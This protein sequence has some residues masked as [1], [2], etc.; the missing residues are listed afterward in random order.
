[1]VKEMKSFKEY[2]DYLLV[3]EEIIEATYRDF[4][5]FQE[6]MM[7]DAAIDLVRQKIGNKNVGDLIAR[8]AERMTPAEF[9]AVMDEILGSRKL[10]N[11]IVV[12]IKEKLS[13]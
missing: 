7:I 12:K 2:E 11:R 10:L 6:N 13:K 9:S 8:A 4:E 5:S 3:E 1:M